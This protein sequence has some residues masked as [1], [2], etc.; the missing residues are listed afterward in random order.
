MDVTA[1][2][3]NLGHVWPIARKYHRFFQSHQVDGVVYEHGRAKNHFYFI[4]RKH[5]KQQ[6]TGT[7]CPASLPSCTQI[8][9]EVV[10]Y[11]S[12]ITFWT[13]TTV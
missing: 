4:Q 5:N 7:V 12:S 2:D 11:I 6:L 13:F 3:L 10:E 1:G 8:V 9:V